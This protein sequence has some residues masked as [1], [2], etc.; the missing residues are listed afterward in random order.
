MIVSLIFYYGVYMITAKINV[1]SLCCSHV[2]CTYLVEKYAS[3][4]SLYPKDLKSRTLVDQRLYFDAATLFPRIRGICVSVNIILRCVSSYFYHKC[5]RKCVKIQFYSL[6]FHLYNTMII[7]IEHQVIWAKV[8]E[9]LFW[10]YL[11][12]YIC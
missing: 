5:N 4:D 3:D 7:V 12:I 2:I 11:I 8:Y 10:V 9:I 1:I 6:I